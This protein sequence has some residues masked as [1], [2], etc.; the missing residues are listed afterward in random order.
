LNLVPR[1]A[2]LLF[3]GFYHAGTLITSGTV[4]GGKVKVRSQV[5]ERPVG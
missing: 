2:S 1:I 4:F 5:S 3:F